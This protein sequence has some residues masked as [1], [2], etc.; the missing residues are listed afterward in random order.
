M[1]DLEITRLTPSYGATRVLTGLDLDGLTIGQAFRKREVEPFHQDLGAVVVVFVIGPVAV[2]DVVDVGIVA[3][4]PVRL[5][6]NVTL[7]RFS[8]SLSR[9]IADS[10]SWPSASTIRQ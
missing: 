4:V 7:F 2:N 9:R 8:N 10:D 1:S 6:V 5:R 3:V